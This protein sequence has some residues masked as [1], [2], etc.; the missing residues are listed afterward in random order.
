M[1]KHHVAFQHIK[2]HTHNK[3]FFYEGNRIVDKLKWT[4]DLD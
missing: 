2:A 4:K 1:C 3:G